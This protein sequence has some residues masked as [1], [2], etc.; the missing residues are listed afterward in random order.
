MPRGEMQEVA[1]RAP[2]KG[3]GVD[4]ETETTTMQ[5]TAAQNRKDTTDDCLENDGS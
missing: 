2:Q 3:T 5:L 4:G 1:A